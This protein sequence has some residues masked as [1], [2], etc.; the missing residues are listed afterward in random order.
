MEQLNLVLV[1]ERYEMS[2]Y[3]CEFGYWVIIDCIVK[4]SEM[5]ER[6]RGRGG[7]GGHR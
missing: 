4:I 1:F 2:T 6:E 3:V 5:R 7:G